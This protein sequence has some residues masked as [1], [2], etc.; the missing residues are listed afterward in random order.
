[1]VGRSVAPEMLRDDAGLGVEPAERRIAER[2]ER[3]REQVGPVV[4]RVEEDD[5]EGRHAVGECGGAGAQ[6]GDRVAL[7]DPRALV[8]ARGLR[9][10][11][12]RRPPRGQSDSMSSARGAPRLSASIAAAPEPANASSIATSQASARSASTIAK[13]ACF[14]RSLSGRVPARG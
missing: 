10:S 8:D 13:S 3:R 14:T 11:R 12:A 4:R 1:M 5:P 7:D 6:E 9:G 2:R